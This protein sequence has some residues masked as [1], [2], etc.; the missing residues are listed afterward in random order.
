MFNVIEF[1]PL[2]V[3]IA[4]GNY[5]VALCLTAKGLK[6]RSQKTYEDYKEVHNLNYCDFEGFLDHLARRVPH[7]EAPLFHVRPYKRT[8]S[9][10]T[11]ETD[12]NSETVGRSCDR[13]S[14]NLES[15]DKKNSGVPRPTAGMF[16]KRY[17]S[18]SNEN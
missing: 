3:A 10:H 4:N 1:T 13:S 6:P 9:C 15:V 17:V 18:Q 14:R 11:S 12:L 8:M 5:R 2:D 16:F 7:S